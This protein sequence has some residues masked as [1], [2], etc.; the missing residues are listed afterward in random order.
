VTD[1][2]RRTGDLQVLSKPD[3][4]LLALTY[5]LELERNGGDWRVRKDPT[6]KRVNGKPP[7]RSEEGEA[8]NA[9]P[10]T[11]GSSV[12]GQQPP[13]SDTSATVENA[14]EPTAEEVAEAV[15]SLE[16]TVDG[17]DGSADFV[18]AEAGSTSEED[19]GDDGDGEWISEHPTLVL[20]RRK[21]G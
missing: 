14:E 5:E 6:Q 4:H 2:S 21:S 19:V 9:N 3:L 10:D 7:G 17:R 13:S 20:C 1:F 12:T 11:D 18:E 15:Q 8:Q 16:I